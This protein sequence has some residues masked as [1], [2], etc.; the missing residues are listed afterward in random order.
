MR[1]DENTYKQATRRI[2]MLTILLLCAMAIIA[3]DVTFMNNRRQWEKL[4]TIELMQKGNDYMN[5][6]N[7]PD[8]GLLCHTI[9][10]N[11][12]NENLQGEELKCTIWAHCHIGATYVDF[13]PNYTEAYKYLLRAKELAEKHH[14]DA[15]L[16]YELMTMGNM[17]WVRDCLNHDEQFY[18]EALEYHKA[19]F[20][21]AID[22]NLLNI[23][24]VTLINLDYIASVR[25]QMPLI[26]KEREKYKHLNLPDTLHLFY[27]AQT[28]NQGVELMLQGHPEQAVEVFR[29]ATQGDIADAAG[30]NKVNMRLMY[31]TYIYLAQRMMGSPEA[32]STL[33]L[34]KDWTQ[35]DNPKY[36]PFPYRLLAE[37]Y[38]EQGN[39]VM[40]EKY[41]LL[42][43]K[44]ADSI[45][46]ASQINNIN[47]VR[48]LHEIDKMNLE[49]KELTCK[50][51][52]KERILWIVGAFSLIAIALLV[53]LYISRR[54]IQEGYKRLYLQNVEL[55]AA[56]EARRQA[57]A[58]QPVATVDEA[59]KY[60]HN[61]MDDDVMDELWPQI[62]RVLET[63]EDIFHDPFGIDQLAELLGTKKN[64]V[65]QTINTKTGEPFTTLLNEYRIR[66]ACRRMNDQEHYGNYSVEGIAQS[67]GYNSRSHFA[68]LFKAATGIPPSAYMR[69]CKAGTPPVP[70]AVSGPHPETLFLK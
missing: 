61:Q 26:A 66:E 32:L 10:A 63:C 37:Y 23:L 53:L 36:M 47:T 30:I 60:S 67:V 6:K 48:F 40:A 29:Q 25:N 49:V 20:W 21:K 50:E 12:Y 38:R 57:E 41:D 7:L 62:K 8:S 16:P 54:R 11:R 13:F 1:A 58:A 55:L 17:Y 24:P 31:Y 9:V 18:K 5:L 69:L 43:Y 39:Q 44:S 3:E 15:L 65:S 28:M 42:W 27:T 51:Q 22:T 34:M 35:K 46:H 4:P 70:P 45:A 2:A 19:A 56:D 68:K 14:Y 64:Y 52:T 33:M 59:P